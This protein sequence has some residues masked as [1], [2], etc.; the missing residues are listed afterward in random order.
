[1][2][3]PHHTVTGTFTLYGTSSELDLLGTSEISVF[4]ST[5]E[6]SGGYGDIDSGSNVTLKDGQGKILASGSLG[7]G[8]P[9]A[10]QCMFSFTLNDVPEVPFYSIEI[11]R[12]GAIT[13]SLEELRSN[14]WKFELSIGL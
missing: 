3:T 9:G 2:L 5:C 6:G 7:P 1:M 8:S 10:G 4:G 13:D 14:G 12:R 11:G